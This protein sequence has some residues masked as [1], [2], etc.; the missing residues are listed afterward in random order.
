MSAVRFS[1]YE[2]AA[3][4]QAAVLFETCVNAIRRG[5]L[6]HREGDKDKE[7]HFQNWFKRRLG[8]LKVNF[9]EGGRNSYPDFRLVNSTEGYEIKGLAYP[10]R[11]TNYDSNSQP[12]CG[13][14][15][16]REVYYAFGRYPAKPDGTSYPVIDFVLCHG[17]FLNAVGDYVHKNKNFR[18]FGSYG[19]IMVRDR[20]MYVV[21]TPFALAE[22][23]A[24]H[25][26]LILPASDSAP[27]GFEAVGELMRREV[28][29]VVCA[30]AFDLRT[31]ELTT[32]KV[33]NPNAGR[34]HRFVA[35]RLKG[36]PHA[37]VRLRDRR[38]VL[39]ALE[40]SVPETDED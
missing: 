34:E 22:N 30:Y 15:N 10:G 38:Q 24:H 3:L 14:Y 26:T 2:V 40:A 31:N 36:E 20:K 37:P 9:E 6:I 8:D 13:H 27:A 16:G 7:F 21:P 18:G 35:Y 19:D 4:S 28:D 29:E 32:T 12:P 17:S 1:T 33:P 39:A 25:R 23:T 5:E 11:E